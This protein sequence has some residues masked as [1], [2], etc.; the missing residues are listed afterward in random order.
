MAGIFGPKLKNKDAETQPSKPLFTDDTDKYHD[1][2]ELVLEG[3]REIGDDDEIK[4]VSFSLTD[5][6]PSEVKAFL[7]EKIDSLTVEGTVHAMSE[8]IK[9]MEGQLI[10]V[11]EINASQKKDLKVMQENVI[12]VD[13]ENEALK[14]KLGDIEEAGPSRAELDLELRQLI[15]E[16]NNNQEKLQDLTVEN[17]KLEL[18]RNDRDREIAMLEEEKNDAQKYASSIESKTV[19]LVAMKKDY[20]D[21]IN[22]LKRE[23][24]YYLEMIK[25]Q[26]NDLSVLK[27]EK[28][29]LEFELKETKE[30]FDE[31]YTELAGIKSKTKNF[32]RD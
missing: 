10:S 23:N 32:I 26:E 7:K 29:V 11:L 4:D 9:S 22:K 28:K 19:N 21:Q 16:L 2:K 8:A 1:I 5:I 6:P 3:R 30:M 18:K 24:L 25:N 15:T 12:K 31:I 14:G 20:E 17:E 27:K 13:K